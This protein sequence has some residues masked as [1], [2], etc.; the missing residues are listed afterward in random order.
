MSSCPEGERH[1]REAQKAEE[2]LRQ[3]LAI[4]NKAMAEAEAAA[5]RMDIP[6]LTAALNRANQ[7]A[8]ACVPL[9]T[10]MDDEYAKAAEE[11]KRCADRA[12]ERGEWREAAN[13]YRAARACGAAGVAEGE[14]ISQD[15]YKRFEREHDDGLPPATGRPGDSNGVPTPD[16]PADIDTDAEQREAER[17]E[18]AAR[19]PANTP[20]QATARLRSAAKH[21]RLAALHEEDFGDPCIAAD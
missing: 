15:S 20:A 10:Q 9:K 8:A 21:H 17:D 13:L 12:L 6:A 18:E 1:F 19:D 3:Q 16:D 4:V 11:F 2:Q 14:G 7:A 5:G